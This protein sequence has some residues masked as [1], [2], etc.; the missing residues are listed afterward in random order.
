[1][2]LTAG[3][4]VG[5]GLQGAAVGAQAV[6][7]AQGAACHPSLQAQQQPAAEPA[8]KSSP[9]VITIS[10]DSESDTPAPDASSTPESEQTVAPAQKVDAA[11][12]PLARAPARSAVQRQSRYPGPPNSGATLTRKRTARGPPLA[13]TG[14]D[15]AVLAAVEPS[16]GPLTA[17]AEQLHPGR[18]KAGRGRCSGCSDRQ[19]S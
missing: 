3:L 2:R 5:A 10:D 6:R 15:A 13:E 4:L 18:P 17:A 12:I 11:C 14:A 7:G 1:M 16:D 9:V 19:A 8:R